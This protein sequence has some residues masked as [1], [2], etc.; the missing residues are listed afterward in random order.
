MTLSQDIADRGTTVS[1]VDF[2]LYKDRDFRRLVTSTEEIGDAVFKCLIINETSG[3][4]LVTKTMA[5]VTGGLSLD[6]LQ[7]EIAPLPERVSVEFIAELQS[8]KVAPLARGYALVFD[9]GGR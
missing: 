3:A 1:H 5:V 9:V 8:G 6:I 2:K 4:V 7:A